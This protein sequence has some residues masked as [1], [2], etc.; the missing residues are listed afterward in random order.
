MVKK[1]NLVKT[2]S[3]WG[4][5][6]AIQFEFKI[7]K[8]PAEWH[9]LLHLTTGENC[10]EKGSRIPGIFLNSDGQGTY[11]YLTIAMTGR[12]KTKKHWLDLNKWLSME[13][14]QK[15]GQFSVVL[16]GVVV[17][18]VESGQEQF[19]NVQFFLS[20]KFYPSAS[21]SVEGASGENMIELRKLIVSGGSH[22]VTNFDGKLSTN[23]Q[24]M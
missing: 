17:W 18:T 23:V 22:E 10:C 6:F 14:N 16:D 9:S 15:N 3:K 13:L 7:L 20:D 4:P 1:N 19:Q 8:R 5:D 11:M 24:A 2:F 21:Y 12:E